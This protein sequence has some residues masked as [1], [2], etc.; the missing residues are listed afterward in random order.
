MAAPSR[1]PSTW[2]EYQYGTSPSASVRSDSAQRSVRFEGGEEEPLLDAECGRQDDV[3]GGHLRHRRRAIPNYNK[4]RSDIW[5]TSSR[6]SMTMRLSNLAQVGGVNSIENF[7]RSWSRAAGFFEVAPNRPSLLY[8][9]NGESS[10]FEPE[11]YDRIEP[12]RQRIPQ[13]GLLRVQFASQNAPES[14]EDDASVLEIDATKGKDRAGR[15]TIGRT[16]E[17][18][19]KQNMDARTFGAPE[20]AQEGESIFA[21]APHLA[22]PLGGSYGTSYGTLQS[23]LNR[24]SMVHAGQLWREQQETGSSKPDGERE[25]LLVKEVEQDGKKVLMVAGQSTL[26]QTVFNSTNVLIGV[27]ILSLPL[28][29]KYAG[30]VC[31]MGFLLLASVMT[32]YTARIL[33]KC[34]DTDRSLVTFADLAFISYG[35]KARIL[36]SILFTLELLAACVALVILFSDT[37]DILIPGVGSTEWKIFCGLLLIPLNFAPLRFLSFTSVLGIFSCFC[38]KSTSSKIL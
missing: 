38:S 8:D 29:I 4:F 12:P 36:T 33:A 11:S 21:I 7:A 16:V 9:A 28:G 15:G 20:T 5:L 14:S 22:T 27:G 34:M 32:W 6:S 37:L 26:P 10:V 19:T 18:G 13:E 2:D 1:N 35:Q 23:T 3:E 17:Q 30:W 25:P 31:G 24:S